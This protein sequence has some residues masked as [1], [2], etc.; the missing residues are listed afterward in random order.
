VGT[1]GLVAVALDDHFRGRENEHGELSRTLMLVIAIHGLYDFFL[2]SS[3][4]S[5]GSFLAMFVFVLLTR[6]FVD[7]LRELPGR[8]GPLLRWFCIGLSVVA[9]ASFVYACTIV[10]PQEA[11]FALLEGV[12]GL[13][14]VTYVFVHEF[15]RI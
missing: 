5:G 1:T 7:V 4:V 2:S 15:G 11:I 8:E 6:R 13:A 12:L 9:G 10:A 3:S 14:I